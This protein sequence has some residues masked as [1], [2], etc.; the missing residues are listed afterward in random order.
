[1][2]AE[3][4]PPGAEEKPEV[5]T[6][7][8]PPPAPGVVPK[9]GAPPAAGP[10]TPRPGAEEQKCAITQ[11]TPE[12]HLRLEAAVWKSRAMNSKAQVAQQAVNMAQAEARKVS[13]QAAR[14]QAVFLT[15]AESFG[16]DTD[17]G[18]E[19]TEQGK[20]IYLDEQGKAAKKK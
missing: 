8:P 17:Q 3:K 11:L 14:E 2:P 4:T 10:A 16:I 19:W 15:L 7:P 13:T 18:F 5:S 20:V 9:P 1:M 12:Q 6:P